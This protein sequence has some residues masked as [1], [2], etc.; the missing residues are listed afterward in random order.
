MMDVLVHDDDLGDSTGLVF[1]IQFSVEASL[2]AG[3]STMRA[4][5]DIVIQ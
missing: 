5:G 2:F 4:G 1:P 3:T